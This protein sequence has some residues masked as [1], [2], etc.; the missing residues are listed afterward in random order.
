MNKII[1]DALNSRSKKTPIWLM[2]QA[3]RFLPEYREVRERAGSFLKLCY[4]PEDASNVTL[5][6][7]KRFDFDAAIIFSDILIVPNSLGLSLDFLQGEGPKLERVKQSSDLKK[8]TISS[9]NWC[10]EKIWE[11]VRKTKSKLE[12]EKT[13]IGFAGAPWT[14]ATYILEGRGKTDFEFSKNKIKTD[15]A[16]IKNLLEIISEQTINYLLGQIENG[17]EVI[18]IF[19]SWAGVLN[20]FEDRDDFI[21][22]PVKFIISEV[23]KKY[24]NIP[25]ISFPKG[26]NYIEEYSKKIKS[27]GIGMGPEVSME[28][29]QK[30]Q[31]FVAIQGNLSPETL[32]SDK[33]NIEKETLN[34]LNS[35]SGPNF[36]FN[37]GHGILPHTPIENVEFLV[38]L[39]RKHEKN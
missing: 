7:I 27:E 17:A 30:L 23:K 18:Q 19:D 10:F 39:V 16:F 25:F 37:L 34:I 13:L 9:K 1:I 6:P 26:I 3:G 33:K 28:E 29:A 22:E 35:L 14:V 21:I 5:Q 31:K 8:L 24:P 15:K 4:S 36:I 38:R 2:R 12:E 20:D 11:T 32:A